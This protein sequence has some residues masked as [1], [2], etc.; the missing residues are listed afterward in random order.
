M[1][2][3]RKADAASQAFGAKVRQIRDER[4]WTLEDLAGQ[5]T[6]RSRTSG[7]QV[8]MDAKSL[9]EIERGWYS[10]TIGTAKRIADGL[11]VSL[12]ELVKD[13]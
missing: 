9:G 11:G 3:R 8:P 5:I 7:K 13:L 1:P 4:G 10:P 6:T 12:G 2:R